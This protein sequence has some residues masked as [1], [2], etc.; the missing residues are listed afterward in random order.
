ML[1]SAC[2]KRV[3]VDKLTEAQVKTLTLK[4]LKS[5]SSEDFEKLTPA[6]ANALTPEQLK[7]LSPK[8]RGTVAYKAGFYHDPKRDF[9]D[10]EKPLPIR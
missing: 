5:I 4:Q 8:N 6:Q 1:L 3:E 9:S 10:S 7:S 2:E